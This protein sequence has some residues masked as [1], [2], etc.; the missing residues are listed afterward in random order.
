MK[1]T[2]FTV[3]SLILLSF[4][5]GCSGPSEYEKLFNVD[6]KTQ[7]GNAHYEVVIPEG[8]ASIQV[9]VNKVIFTGNPTKEWKEGRKYVVSVSGFTNLREIGKDIEKGALIADGTSQYTGLVISPK[10]GAKAGCK[11]K[12]TKGVVTVEEP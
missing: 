7:E 11:I 8:V 5:V 10:K 9:D 3:I 4:I 6:F 2:I 12:V 1:R